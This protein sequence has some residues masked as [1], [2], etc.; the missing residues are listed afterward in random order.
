VS[1]NDGTVSTTAL[2]IT[3]HAGTGNFGIGAQNGAA[4]FMNGN[5]DELGIWTRKLS[6]AEATE[7][8][9]SGNGLLYE[10]YDA[11]LLT[12]LQGYWRFDEDGGGE[13][14]LDETANN[15]D[16]TNN[17]TA[18]FVTD[19]P[20][21]GSIAYEIIAAV[22][23]FTLTGIAAILTSARNIVAAVGTFTLTGIDVALSRGKMIV[24]GVGAF[25]LTGIDATITSARS[26]VAAVGAF[27]LTG[28]D[29]AFNIG[30]NMVASVGTFVT[31]LKSLF[32]DYW[33]DEAEV[34]TS[35][36][37]ESAVTTTFT[38]ESAVTTT[39]KDKD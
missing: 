3:T 34:S 35:W 22:G 9:N 17:N 33:K 7:I 2:T 38:D 39:W 4:N 21:T 36:T 16:L 10:D 28:I 25:T 14:L 15:N 23:A 1:V 27:T 6:A 8:Y 37:D 32:I 30:W 26:M 24:A 12:S 29:T 20:F 13:G 31:S 5:I 18:T 11:G 19:V